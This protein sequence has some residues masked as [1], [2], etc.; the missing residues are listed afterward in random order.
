MQADSD[1]MRL[2]PSIVMDLRGIVFSEIAFGNVEE[3]SREVCAD[4]DVE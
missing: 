4:R 1:Q 3:L 2:E